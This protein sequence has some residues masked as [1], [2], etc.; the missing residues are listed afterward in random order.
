MP[1]P[2]RQSHGNCEGA[3][4]ERAAE[5]CSKG[6]CSRARMIHASAGRAVE[7]RAGDR[8]EAFAHAEC[9][10]PGLSVE[11]T[12]LSKRR[13]TASQTCQSPKSALWLGSTRVTDTRSPCPAPGK[14]CEPGGPGR[15]GEHPSHPV[16]RARQPHRS[17]A[18]FS[19]EC[20][21]ERCAAARGSGATQ[22]QSCG[23][24]SGNGDTAAAIGGR[25]ERVARDV[26]SVQLASAARRTSGE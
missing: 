26:E 7:T 23:P 6:S 2:S 21:G 19:T 8:R 11:E 9:L 5:S 1:V 18:T 24:V 16:P 22:H 4:D 10:S 3:R 20:A 13:W 17:S 14:H 15:D 12:M 25:S